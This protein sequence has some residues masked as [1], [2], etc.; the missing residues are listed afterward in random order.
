[1]R[2]YLRQHQSPGDILMLTAAVRDLKAAFP[3]IRVNVETTAMDLW[4]NNPLLD[5]GV[6]PSNAD[7]Q[8]ELEYPL[9]HH[10]SALPYHFVHA[11]RK[12]LQIQL[13]LRIPQGAFRGDVYLSD[14]EREIHPDVRDLGRYWLIDA[15]YK[16]DFP[17]KHW[18]TDHFLRLAELL[19]D[20]PL[21][22]I[23]QQTAGHT[24]PPIPGARNLIGK[25]KI[26]DLIRLMYR[27]EGVITPVS[28]PMHL[29]AA[30]PT[31]DG[32]LRPAVVLAGGREAA[33]WEAYPGHV[34]LST[35]GALDCCRR[36]GC[37][38]STPDARN[39]CAHPVT[40]GSER[41]GKC[42]TMIPPEHVAHWVRVYHAG[43]VV[44]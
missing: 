20:V 9:V 33:H 21:V 38:R 18:G 36:G 32:R 41:I 30:V 24:H 44:K 40:L 37:W 23:G 43:A 39:A 5:P 42:M 35:V 19:P 34:H 8:I 15:G 27:A 10:S 22:Q 14:A 1:M 31:P 12:E 25:T 4:A 29:A 7:R 16:S 3:D 28:F 17:L 2:L 11:F 13:G 6:T 26:R